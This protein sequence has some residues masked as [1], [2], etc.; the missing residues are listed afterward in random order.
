MHQLLLAIAYP[1]DLRKALIGKRAR[2]REESHE[3][4]PAVKQDANDEIRAKAATVRSIRKN[5]GISLLTRLFSWI[6]LALALIA[7]TIGSADAKSVHLECG[8]QEFRYV[9]DFDAGKVIVTNFHENRSYIFSAQISSVAINWRS[10][11]F[12]NSLDRSTLSLTMVG[13]RGS[14]AMVTCKVVAAQPKKI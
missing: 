1:R 5:D 2:D 3:E 8:S 12:R 14:R 4:A 13:D 7:F 11:R 10:G 6:A 9:I